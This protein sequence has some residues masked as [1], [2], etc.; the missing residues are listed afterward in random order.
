MK[1]VLALSFF[2]CFTV[3][4]VTGEEFTKF[5]A[6][7]YALDFVELNLVQ[8]KAYQ[9]MGVF[10]RLRYN[11]LTDDEALKRDN[12]EFS[13]ALPT[14]KAKLSKLPSG[15]Q[16]VL[17]TLDYAEAAL[18]KERANLALEAF[19]KCRPYVL[20]DEKVLNAENNSQLQTRVA[21]L[22]ASADN[23]SLKSSL[24]TPQLSLFLLVLLQE[25]YS[26][27][28]NRPLRGSIPA[29]L[30]G[31]PAISFIKNLP[32]PLCTVLGDCED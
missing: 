8:G 14:A 32:W 4:P 17:K 28:E 2:A 3:L 1:R 25:E 29:R 9:E 13:F 21:R 18:L 20:S 23:G 16:I 15:F 5:S 19:E 31:D 10:Q 26:S 27:G 24:E 12:P 7:Q 11:V 6:I 30:A 22:T